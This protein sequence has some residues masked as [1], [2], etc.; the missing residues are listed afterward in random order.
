MHLDS[1]K[2]H[3]NVLKRLNAINKP[4]RHLNSTKIGV[5]RSTLSRLSKNKPITLETFFKLLEWLNH[6]PKKYIIK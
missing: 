4:Q 2:L 1:Q 6:E 3:K 5:S